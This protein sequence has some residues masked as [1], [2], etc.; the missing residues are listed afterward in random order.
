MSGVLTELDLLRTE[1]PGEDRDETTVL[2]PEIQVALFGCE[3]PASAR[4]STLAPGLLIMGP[5]FAIWIAR[6]SELVSTSM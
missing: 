3:R 1:P 2:V 6:S 5:S 4:I